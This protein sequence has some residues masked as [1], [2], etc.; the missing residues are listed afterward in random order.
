MNLVS[1]VVHGLSAMAVFGDRIGVRLLVVVSMGMSLL[2]GALITVIAIRLLTSLAIPGWATYVAGLL[3][4]ILIQMLIV[5]LVFAFVIL[6]GR[7]TVS[8]IPSRDYVHV[9]DAVR[10]VYGSRP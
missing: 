10:R 3:L 5:V 1:L 4:V 9:T 8:I 2:S 7:D 6:S